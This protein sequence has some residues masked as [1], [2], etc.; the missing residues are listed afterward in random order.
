MGGTAGTAIGADLIVAGASMAAKPRV[1]A[2]LINILPA[3][4]AVEARRAATD[5]RRLKGQALTTIGAG[6]GSTGVSLLT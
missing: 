5:V 2:A 4:G 3:G 1:L 6:V